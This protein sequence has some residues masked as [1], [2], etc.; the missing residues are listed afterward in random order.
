M[1]LWLK[2]NNRK[3][4]EK[5]RIIGLIEDAQSFVQEHKD[6]IRSHGT[7]VQLDAV[8]KLENKLSCKMEQEALALKWVQRK[9]ETDPIMATFSKINDTLKLDVEGLEKM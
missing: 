8:N 5:Q 6:T 9:K 4:E 1:F 3:I 2:V 7:W